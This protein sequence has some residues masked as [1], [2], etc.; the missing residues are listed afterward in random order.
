MLLESLL[1][2]FGLAPILMVHCKIIDA[3]IGPVVQRMAGGVLPTRPIVL[4]EAIRLA[5]ALILEVYS[6]LGIKSAWEVGKKK[7]LRN[8]FTMASHCWQN[9]P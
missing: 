3:K 9:K 6:A 1:I 4:G 8:Q 2:H 7:S 5:H